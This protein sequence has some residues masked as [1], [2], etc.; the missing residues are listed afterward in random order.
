MYNYTDIKYTQRLLIRPLEL[1]DI[2]VWA[3]YLADKWVSDNDI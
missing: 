3:H 1:G 2:D